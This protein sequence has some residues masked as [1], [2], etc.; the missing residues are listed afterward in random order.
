MRVVQTAHGL[1]LTAAREYAPGD[2]I[3]MYGVG[4]ELCNEERQLELR[5]STYEY[6]ARY[7]LRMGG[8]TV[9][10][11]GC[12]TLAHLAN[13]AYAVGTTA[14]QR[15]RN[16]KEYGVNTEIWGKGPRMPRGVIKYAAKYKI[17]EGELITVEYGDDYWW[18]TG[19]PRTGGV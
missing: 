4:C 15:V 3:V 16:V 10:G 13:A 18:G 12:A 1:G 17:A 11:R 14:Q 7:M 9:D 6:K 2:P 8:D 19:T 5:R